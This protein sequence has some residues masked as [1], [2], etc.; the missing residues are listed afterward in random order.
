MKKLILSAALIICFTVLMICPL[1]VSAESRYVGLIATVIPNGDDPQLD[2]AYPAVVAG[3]LND[4]MVLVTDAPKSEDTSN[5][6]FYTG[7]NLLPI[8]YSDGNYCCETIDG[9]IAFCKKTKY[10]EKNKTYT[11]YYY[12]DEIN[13]KS[14]SVVL[15]D[16]KF[17]DS[18]CTFS[19]G[20]VPD[21]IY[22]YGAVVDENGQMVGIINE[23]GV[24]VGWANESTVNSDNASDSES[25]DSENT[26]NGMDK[27]MKILVVVGAA[28][29]LIALILIILLLRRNS[30]RKAKEGMPA[31]VGGGVDVPIAPTQP[32]IENLPDAPETEID[33]TPEIEVD[34]DVAETNIEHPKDTGVG[35]ITIRCLSGP[36]E[37]NEY[38]FTGAEMTVG[39]L[40]GS[41]I[42]FPPDTK[43]V[44]KRHCKLMMH[45][46]Q[47]VIVDCGSTFGTYLGENRLTPN[48]P[49]P[50]RKSDVFML[51]DIDNRFFI[52]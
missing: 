44:S 32:N 15:N 48:Q 20:Q 23:N 51:G 10:P 31:A 49:V 37:G 29:V 14:T 28:I 16:I 50:L 24:S 17:E 13:Y 39:R 5:T 25:T 45:N 6:Y 26:D 9:D 38:T 18:V 2:S 8:T 52:C 19:F 21:D 3:K 12:N 36:L 11:F 33:D 47:F 40:A 46:G 4:M 22:G 42:C 27:D 43:G 35:G 41:D 34:D 30:K 1:T 7:E